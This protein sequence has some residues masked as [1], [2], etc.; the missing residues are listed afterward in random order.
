LIDY[1]SLPLIAAAIILLALGTSC[2][3][4]GDRVDRITR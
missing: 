3:W 1:I 2:R 4:C